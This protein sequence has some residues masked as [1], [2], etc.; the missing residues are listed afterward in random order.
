MSASSY[1][2][3][4]SEKYQA[5]LDKLMEE[6]DIGNSM[7]SMSLCS[8]QGGDEIATKRLGMT[9]V[10]A[11]EINR[12]ARETC[13][14]NGLY[15]GVMHTDFTRIAKDDLPYCNLLIAGLPCQSFSRGGLKNGFLDMRGSLFF[16]FWLIL[17][18]RRPEVAIIENVDHLEVIDGGQTLKTMIEPC[19]SG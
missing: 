1:A 8:G 15:K 7:T 3:L 6:C 18:W 11:A 17:N 5:H 2:N 4:E 10:L 19:L 12:W 14:K 13:D 9:C 16:F